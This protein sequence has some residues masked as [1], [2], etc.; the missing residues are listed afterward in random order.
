MLSSALSAQTKTIKIMP[1]VRP[2]IVL[3]QR[4]AKFSALLD[5]ISGG[6]CLINIVNGWWADDSIC[7]ATARGPMTRPSAAGGS[8]SLFPC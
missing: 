6:R 7:M 1:A 4:V 2:G 3:P 5:R 8:T